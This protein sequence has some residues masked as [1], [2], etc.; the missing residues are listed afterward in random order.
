MSPN[1]GSETY[2]YGCARRARGFERVVRTRVRFVSDY[3]GRADEFG[4]PHS[5]AGGD[6]KPAAQLDTPTTRSEDPPELAAT[7]D[8]PVVPEATPNP[9]TIRFVTPPIHDGPSRWYPSA[10]DVD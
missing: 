10:T 8:G 1:A 9:R 4:L 6:P 2:T 7:F 5:R 3:A